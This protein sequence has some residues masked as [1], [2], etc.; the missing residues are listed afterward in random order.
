[1]GMASHRQRSSKSGNP[2]S[3]G[4]QDRLLSQRENTYRH[5]PR[6]DNEGSGATEVNARVGRSRDDRSQEAGRHGTWHPPAPCYRACFSFTFHTSILRR[7]GHHQRALQ[8]LKFPHKLALAARLGALREPAVLLDGLPL[9]RDELER[10]RAVLHHARLHKPAADDEARAADAAPAV[11]GGDAAAL[12]V[13][14]EHVEDLSDVADG[15]GQ[16]AVRDGEGV[17]L[18][19]LLVLLVDADAA[20]VC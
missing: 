7:D 8:A 4:H 6:T 20:H 3:R 16:A 12:S 15:A 14:L 10:L 5:G 9:L 18:H 13:V 11:H 1:M 19:L 17:V 2:F